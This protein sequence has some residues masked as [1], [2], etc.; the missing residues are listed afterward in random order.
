M[1]ETAAREVQKADI[2]LII[3]TS[4][5]VYPAAGLVSYANPGIPVYLIDPKPI[6]LPYSNFTQIEEVAT[7][8]MEEFTDI[9]KTKA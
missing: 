8:G 5:V 6:H 9:I 7:K 2:L 1:I 4:M 3:G